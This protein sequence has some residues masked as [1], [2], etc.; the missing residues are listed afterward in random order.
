MTLHASTLAQLCSTPLFRSDA[1]LAAHDT[2]ASEF[3]EHTL[4]WRAGKPDTAMHKTS[5]NE[6]HFYTLRYGPEVEVAAHPFDEFVLIHTSLYGGMEIDCDGRK[7]WMREGSSAVLAPATGIRLRWS[8]RNHQMIVKIPRRLLEA[9][10][11]HGDAAAGTLQGG[12][13]LPQALELQWSLL[14]Q[15]ALA[16]LPGSG[17]ACASAPWTAHLER[18]IAT[19][20]LLHARSPDGAASTEPRG[21]RL[22]HTQTHTHTG[23]AAI[24]A[25]VGYVDRHLAGPIALQDLALATGLSIRTVNAQCRRHFGMTPLEVV[26]NRRLDAVRRRLLVDP[27]ASI[28]DTALNCGFGHLGRFSAYY[29]ARFNEL[30]RAT[31][32]ACRQG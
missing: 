27:H 11:D 10:A 19:F 7:L 25:I 24:D 9:A 17:S 8:P 20:V 31:Q 6:I 21:A 28:T 14:V 16:A 18:T 4:H 3:A 30:P 2:V 15:T 5:L 1:R 22:A 12:W 29:A 26:R 13:L 32:R 23:T